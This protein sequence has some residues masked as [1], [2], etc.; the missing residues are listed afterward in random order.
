[1]IRKGMMEQ[2]ESKKKHPTNPKPKPNPPP[3]STKQ[4]PNFSVILNFTF[5]IAVHPTGIA[6]SIQK[7][8]C[9][10]GKNSRNLM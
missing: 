4:P 10:D 8:I 9:G 7:M 1:M 6:Q 5:H 3:P 2:W